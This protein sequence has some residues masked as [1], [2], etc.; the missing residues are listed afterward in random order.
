MNLKG[1]PFEP[2]N[3]PQPCTEGGSGGPGMPN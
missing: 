2:Y 1:F 3:N